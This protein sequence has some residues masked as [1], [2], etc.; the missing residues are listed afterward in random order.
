VDEGLLARGEQELPKPPRL[1]ELAEV[2]ADDDVEAVL[3]PG[4]LVESL[5]LTAEREGRI[6]QIGLDIR[7]RSVQRRGRPVAPALRGGGGVSREAPFL[8]A[9]CLSVL[10]GGG[11]SGPR[12]W[13][14][15]GAERNE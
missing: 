15:H 11:A 7:Q 8:E 1:R 10:A 12:V 5:H 6:D 9:A 4:S 3:A 14:T 13:R 2:A